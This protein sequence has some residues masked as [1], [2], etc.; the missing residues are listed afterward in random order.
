[1]WQIGKPLYQFVEDNNPRQ[2]ATGAL[3]DFG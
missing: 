2:G 1:L 3:I